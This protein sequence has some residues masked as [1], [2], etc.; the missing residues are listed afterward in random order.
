M[1]VFTAF[2]CGTGSN[3]FDFSNKD[4]HCGELISSLARR[5][6]GM[7]FVDWIILDGPGSG[8]HQEDEKFVKPAYYSM[9]RGQA[10]GSGWE[11]NVAHAIAVVHGKPNWKRFYMDKKAYDILAQSFKGSGKE[12]H[13]NLEEE[14]EIIDPFS[15]FSET[16]YFAKRSVT[17]QDLQEQKIKIFRKSKGPITQINAIGWSRGGVTTHMFANALYQ[18]QTLRNIPVNII[19]VDPVPGASNFQLHRTSIPQNVKNYVAFYAMDERSVGFTPTLPSWGKETQA[20]IYSLPGK[21]STLVGNAGNFIDGNGENRFFAPGMVVRMLSEKYLTSWGT[22]LDGCVPYSDATILSL[23][24]E[25]LAQVEEFKKLHV[26]VYTTAQMIGSTRK[27]S[28]AQ[29]WQQTYMSAVQLLN[30]DSLALGDSRFFINWHHK[31]LF[32]Q[33]GGFLNNTPATKN[34]RA[35]IKRFLRNL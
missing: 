30:K 25:M 4:Y 27:V 32:F 2:F 16:N 22:K 20:H 26:K 19:A 10:F 34:V 3:S 24:D 1:A 31:A 17:Q 15:G 23:Y 11:E 29:D 18:D 21:H 5:C 9:A 6:S 13:L 8:N 12:F 35:Q 33:F 7:E 14:E 28:V